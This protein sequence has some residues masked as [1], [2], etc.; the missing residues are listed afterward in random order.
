M[1]LL[2]PYDKVKPCAAKLTNVDDAMR[3]VS[4]CCEYLFDVFHYLNKKKEY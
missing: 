4:K 2:H 1:K 3:F